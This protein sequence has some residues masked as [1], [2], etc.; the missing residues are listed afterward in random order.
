MSSA[1]VAMTLLLDPLIAEAGNVV[2]GDS[3]VRQDLS[4]AKVS[5]PLAVSSTSG[6]ILDHPAF[7]SFAPLIL[8]WDGRGYDRNM[9]LTDIGSL[10]PYHTE[11]APLTVVTSLNR[12]I[13]DIDDAKQVFYDIYSEAEKLADPA[14]QN[15]GL[16]YF[17]GKPGAPFAI[18]A[19]GGGF[20]Y[21]GS[22]HEGFPYAVEISRLGYNVFVIRYRTG[23]GSRPATEDLAAAISYVFENASALDIDTDG[24]SLWG[25]SAGARMAAYIGSHGAA[26]FGGDDLPKPAAVIMA[27]T[28]HSD[29]ANNEPPTFA[30]V[31]EDDGIAPPSSM[32][33]R[34]NVLR[35]LGT[36]VEFTIYP[37]VAHGFG[38][39]TQTPAEGWID[40]G[41]DFW[42]AARK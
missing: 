29:H 35:T 42:L 21:V 15:T 33:S 12:M 32:E 10:L 40:D 28:A 8:P 36:R 1:L 30:V 17:R 3:V 5:G 39:G 25:S 22:V 11:V 13:M 38:I 4:S 6:D 27:Y 20:A 24:Y 37:G 9:P 41:V 19:P 31:G 7:S 26:A 34:I 23:Q 14:K 2:V 16:F 18:V